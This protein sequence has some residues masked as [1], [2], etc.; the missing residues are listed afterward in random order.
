MKK[1]IYS[2]I[3]ILLIL[4]TSQCSDDFLVEDQKAVLTEDNLGVDEIEGL[5]IAAYNLDNFYQLSYITHTMAPWI[6]GDVRSDDSYKGGASLTDQPPWHE[7]ELFTLTTSNIGNNNEP[8]CMAYISIS[9]INT[10]LRALYKVSETEFPLR[11]QRIAEMRFLRGYW[12]LKLKRAWRWIPYIVE[13]MTVDDIVHLSNRPDNLTDLQLWGKIEEDMKYAIERLPETQEDIGRINKFTAKAFLVDVLLWMAYEQNENHQ[14]VNINT[15][16]LEEALVHCNDIISSEKYA[17]EPDF[18]H[19][20]MPEYDNLTSEAVFEHQYTYNDGTPSGNINW[21]YRLCTPQWSPYYSC[22][23]FHKAT[24]NLVLAFRTSADGLPLFDTFNDVEVT[25]SSD[26]NDVLWNPNTWDPRISHTIGIPGH[27]YKYVPD[28]LF[29]LAGSRN[30]ALYGHFC[31]MKEQVNP[32]SEYQILRRGNAKNTKEIRYAE[33]L[34]WKAEILI[35]LG[36]EDEALPIINEIRQRAAASTGKLKF[37]D[38]T[39]LMNYNIAQYIDGENCTWDNDFAWKALMWETRLETALEGRRFFNLMRWG[40]AASVINEYFTVEKERFNWIKDGYFRSGVNE[41]MPI[42][43]KQI[44][45]SKGIYKQ[46]P[47]Y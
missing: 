2:A 27:P 29:S 45:E 37:A 4:V 32:L 28:L 16:R 3:A 12:H 5:I 46:N 40:I 8:W 24:F 43:Q 20:F 22:C 33:V 1:C 41:Y 31:S 15:T 6:F 13:D 47:G 39:P 30:P 10:A 36:R 18:A 23:D 42:P 44:N 38:G 7:M 25:Y 35:R 21:G 26:Y 17:L 9:R 11:E 34:L 14:L 19:N